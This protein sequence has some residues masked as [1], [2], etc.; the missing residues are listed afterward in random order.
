MHPV[1]FTQRI[2][3]SG[4]VALRIYP[5]CHASPVTVLVGG[6]PIRASRKSAQWC[7]ASLDACWEQK[8]LRIRSAELQEAASA[9]DHARAAYDRI[10]AESDV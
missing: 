4:W 7:R 2:S 6:K 1:Q 3:R 5:S 9:Y 10:I 8:K